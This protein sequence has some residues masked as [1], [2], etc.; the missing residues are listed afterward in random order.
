MTDGVLNAGVGC[1]VGGALG[2][3]ERGE[4]RD[5]RGV[6]RGVDAKLDTSPSNAANVADRNKD[7]M[8]ASSLTRLD[9]EGGKES[10]SKYSFF[11]Q[12]TVLSLQ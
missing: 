2:F 8:I 3:Q 7:R 9:K 6:A 5:E 1:L 4:K 12:S 11:Y 10:G